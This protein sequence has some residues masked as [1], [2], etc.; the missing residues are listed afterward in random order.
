MADEKEAKSP[1]MKYTKEELI[2]G[3]SALLN[4][5][6]FEVAGALHDCE[7]PITLKEAQRRLEAFLKKKEV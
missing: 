5:P 1:E 6:P 7:K 3:A 4:S 2:K